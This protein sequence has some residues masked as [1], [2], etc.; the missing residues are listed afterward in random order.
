MDA[1]FGSVGVSLYPLKVCVFIH[2]PRVWGL[3]YH[4]KVWVFIHWPRVCVCVCVSLLVYP[5]EVWVLVYI[6]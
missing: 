2:S 3:V 4:L 6:L 1:S 5:L